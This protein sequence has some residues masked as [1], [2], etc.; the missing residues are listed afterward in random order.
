MAKSVVIRKYNNFAA[1][2]GF[3]VSNGGGLPLV[4]E[5]LCDGH[6]VWGRHLQGI[7]RVK[8][9]RRTLHD[10]LVGRL[11]E[12]ELRRGEI[13]TASSDDRRG[14]GEGARIS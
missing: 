1:L 6:V 4:N 9:S 3:L 12:N 2:R 14:R 10:D 5:A 7:A 13:V 8:V 11:W